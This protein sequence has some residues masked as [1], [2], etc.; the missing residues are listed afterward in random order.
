MNRNLEGL[1]SLLGI[2][3]MAMIFSSPPAASDTTAWALLEGPGTDTTVVIGYT[4]V[5]QEHR[6]G[7]TAE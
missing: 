6:P 5:N 7:W 1:E 2:P 4:S 3:G